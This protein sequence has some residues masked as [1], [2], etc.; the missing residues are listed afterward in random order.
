MA[1]T[2]Q[3]VGKV[4]TVTGLI[5]PEE[6]GIAMMHEHLLMD[7]TK[8]FFEEPESAVDKFMAHQ[9]VRLENLYWMRTHWV[10]NIDNMQLMDVRCAI[11]E[12]R[13]YKWAGGET[14]VEVSS[15]GLSR[16]PAG[17]FCP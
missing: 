3:A 13:L 12:A 2:P 15:I 11:E 5:E 14:I 6:V 10:N 7:L 1:R 4:Q 17:L 9:P 16:D 8:G